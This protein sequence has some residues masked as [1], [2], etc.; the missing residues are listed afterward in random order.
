MQS[1]PLTKLKVFLLQFLSSNLAK[2]LILNILLSKLVNQ[3]W[4][5]LSSEYVL[6]DQESKFIWV[7]TGVLNK[8]LVG[9]LYVSLFQLNFDLVEDVIH[10]FF[11]PKKLLHSLN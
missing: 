9:T 1:Q 5:K 7:F 2:S 8:V 11:T 6:L 4:V 3:S 10:R